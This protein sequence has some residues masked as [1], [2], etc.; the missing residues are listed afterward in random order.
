MI[1]KWTERV[2]HYLNVKTN[3]T[4]NQTPFIL[5]TQLVKEMLEN[6]DVKDLIL[7]KLCSE[8]T[9]YIGYLNK[10]IIR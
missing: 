2:N 3:F 4:T 7:N 5:V 10:K 9:L 8:Y 1:D 6:I